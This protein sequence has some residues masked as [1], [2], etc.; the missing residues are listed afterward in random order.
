LGRPARGPLFVGAVF[1]HEL[2]HVNDFNDDRYIDYLDID[3]HH[4]DDDSNDALNSR[5]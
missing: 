3:E 4:I 2:E 1:D 5:I